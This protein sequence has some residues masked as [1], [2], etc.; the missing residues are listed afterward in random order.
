M[1]I[2]HWLAPV[3]GTL[4]LALTAVDVFMTVFHP[5]GHGGPLLRRQTRIVWG[6]FRAFGRDG[7]GRPRA[8]WLAFGGPVLALLTPLVW[9]LLLI[10]GFALL[11]F[12][13]AH[14][15]HISPGRL[16]SD[17]I[18]AVYLSG[19]SATTLGI[20][21]VV[22]SSGTLRLLVVCEAL[23]G[24]A[25]VSAAISYVLAVYR[26]RAVMSALARD[27]ATHLRHGDEPFPRHDAPTHCSAWA[28][29]LGGVGAALGQLRQSHAQYP[30]L[31]YFRPSDPA[32]ALPV[33]LGALLA[34]SRRLRTAAPGTPEA[35]LAAYP[36]AVAFM[37]ALDAYLSLVD[38]L[39]VPGES[40]AGGT[41][42]SGEELEA[43]LDRL[44]RYFLYE[45]APER[46]PAA[47]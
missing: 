36:G 42:Q 47:A 31:H 15:F 8:Q 22:P 46:R 11:F 7:R 3:G 16:D 14:G 24:F 29:W 35:T 23:S 45:A 19:Y 28:E 4:L 38:R 40:I 30:L 5:E 34:L 20:G 6:V 18:A 43:A 10:A 39:F 33:Q 13:S 2:G 37:H 1:T 27:V 17:W 41:G 44:R 26:E 9:I 12:P 32:A 21:D 25:L